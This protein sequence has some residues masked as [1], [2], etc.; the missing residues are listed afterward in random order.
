MAAAEQHPDRDVILAIGTCHVDGDCR[1]HPDWK[2]CAPDR[3]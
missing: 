3:D 2:A 1:R